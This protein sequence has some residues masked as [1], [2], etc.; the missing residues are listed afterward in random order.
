MLIATGAFTV[1]ATRGFGATVVAVTAVAPWW[2]IPAFLPAFVS[3]NLGLSGYLLVRYSRHVRWRW[4]GAVLL[5]PMLAGLP[6]G[7][8]LGG[9]LSNIWLRRLFGAFAASLAALELGALWRAHRAREPGSED[10]PRPA[11]PR[12]RRVALLLAGG[13]VHGLFAT[14]GPMAVYVAARDVRQPGAFRATLA[15]LW[16]SLNAVLVAA[17]AARSQ[18]GLA[19]AALAGAMLPGLALGI[20]TGE[21]LHRRVPR[22]H[23]AAAVYALLLGAGLSLLR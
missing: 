16:F 2:S 3:L 4:L 7:W 22:H 5:P 15:V 12:A 20:A 23:F 21:W 18:L 8:W 11:L 14:G 19:H 9:V 10:L 1:E 17:F 6:L 13:L